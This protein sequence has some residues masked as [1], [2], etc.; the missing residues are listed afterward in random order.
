MN[1]SSCPKCGSTDRVHR[2]QTRGSWERA[3]R[4]VLFFR[5]YRCHRCG[6]RYWVW[7]G[8]LRDPA[9]ARP[10]SARITLWA[11]LLAILLS[12]AVGW[13]LVTRLSQ[14]SSEAPSAAP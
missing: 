8:P 14:E 1:R 4:A 2:S 13:F 7:Q 10:K 12:L 6:Q 9:K 11:I 3:A 5:P